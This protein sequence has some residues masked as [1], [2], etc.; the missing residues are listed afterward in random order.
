MSRGSIVKLPPKDRFDLPEVLRL[1]DPL[2]HTREDLYDFLRLGQLHA[3]CYP[4]R[5][6]A[7]RVIGIEPDEWPEWWR[8]AWSF[9]VFDGFIGDVDTAEFGTRIPLNIIPRAARADCDRVLKDGGKAAASTPVYVLRNELI[10]FTKW[11]HNP[12][13]SRP[14]PRCQGA[15]RP[16]KHDYSAIDNCLETLLQEIGLSGFERIS[17]ITT[18]L[19]NHL[20]EAGLPPDSTL[21]NHINKWLQQPTEAN[22]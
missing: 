1:L 15:G 17:R 11:L 21:R 18:H 22:H 3:V 19:R 16:R 7:D 10:R 12:T 8:D 9:P 20:G 5:L 14:G 13:K 6:E 2:G 4:Y